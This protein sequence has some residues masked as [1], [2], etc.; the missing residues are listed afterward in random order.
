M[1]D[2]PWSTPAVVLVT[3]IQ[4]AGKTTVG[5][6]LSRR[7]TRS[8][9]IDGDDLARMVV[10]GRSGMTPDAP[11][12]AVAQ[13]HLR[14]QQAAMLADSFHGSGFTAVIADNIYGEDLQRFIDMIQARP[15]ISVV[16]V[17]NS[18]AVIARELGR[19]YGAYNDWL[20]GGTLE[21]AVAT[22]QG[23]LATTSRLGLWIDTSVQSP[24]ATVNEFLAR[25]WTEGR[26]L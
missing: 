24:E 14:Y 6:L 15:L 20:A 9:F 21:D 12:E 25:A 16:L 2:V 18:Q 7:L 26:V 23:Y 3:G 10:S 11:T 13:L 22:F 1:T 19:G 17:P 8:A 4:A 5:K